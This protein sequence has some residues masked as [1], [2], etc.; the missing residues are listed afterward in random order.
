[1]NV[2]ST[3]IDS[4]PEQVWTPRSSETASTRIAEFADFVSARTGVTYPEYHDLW[5]FSTRHLAEFWAAI[6]DYFDII[7]DDYYTDV[8]T[9]TAMPGANWFPGVRLN[10]AEHALRDRSATGPALI[11][12]NESGTTTETTWEQLRGQVAAF[13]H[14]LR[15]QGVTAGDRVV[16]YLPNSVHAVV[17]FLGTASIGAVWS[18]CGQD[19]GAAGATSRFAQLEPV[20]LV[21]ADGYQWNGRTHDRRDEVAELRRNLPSVRAVVTVPAL[22]LSPGGADYVPWDEVTTGTAELTFTR[23]D[24]DSPLW[25]LFSS[26]TTG[27]PKGIVHG[28]GGVTLDHHKLLGLHYNLRAEDR[29]FWYTTPNWMM[30]NM[31]VSGLLVGATIVL[32]DG[33]PTHPGPQRLWDIAAEH[34]V[35]VLG[36]SPGYLLTSAKTGLEPGRD[37]DLRALKVIGC[38]GAPLAAQSYQWVHDHVG[39]SIQLASTSGGTDVVSGFA[40]SAP[41]TAV[42]AGE[43]S[44]P[45]LG[46]A[47]AAWNDDGVPVIDEV[48]ELVITEPMP[49]MPIYF[50]DDPDGARYHDAYFTTY[51]GVWRHGDW[52]TVTSHGSVVISGR[53]DSTLN[54]HG[55][56]LGS[57]DVYD[58]VED[59]P[60]IREALVIGAELSDGSYWM[61]LFVILEPGSTLDEVLRGRI[62]AAIRTHASPRHVPDEIISVPAIPH[63]RTGKK[64]EVP[65]KRLLQGTALHEIAGT[66]TI[67]D[68]A[69]LQYFTRF[70]TT[71][72]AHI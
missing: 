48:G 27:R 56:R 26:G 25:V 12:V 37:H 16:G 38:T 2:Q 33:S 30:W 20:V 49:S 21:A 32:Y 15:H 1:M 22:G 8:V 13:A 47:L 46:V 5:S 28:H 68:P 7:A 64:L 50:W 59:L 3:S 60:E 70:G 41:T 17:A 29:Y 23:V 35:S 36:V 55:V 62:T 10:Y 39:D 69:A 52:I 34:R 24:F 9:D 72:K 57:A 6:W 54:R 58:V 66:D 44:A 45:L 31:V 65:V 61:P 63:T 11:S 53:S 51:P 71:R 14:W 40:G 4:V 18:A 19:Y 67:D 42:W 43:I